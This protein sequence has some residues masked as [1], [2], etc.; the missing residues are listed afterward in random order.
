MQLN[1]R[2]FLALSLIFYNLARLAN[3]TAST[4][5]TEHDSK[6]SVSFISWN[7]E[8]S[9]VEDESINEQNIEEFLN[10]KVSLQNPIVIYQ[11][12]NFHLLQQLLQPSS[13]SYPFLTNFFES[14]NLQEMQTPSSFEPSMISDDISEKNLTRFNIDTLPSTAGDLLFNNEEIESSSIVWFQFNDDSYDLNTLDEF[15]EST[16]IFLNENTSNDCKFNVFLNS[17][18]YADNDEDLKINELAQL[19]HKRVSQDIEAL[20][21]EELKKKKN[22][23]KEDGKDDDDKLSKIWT[24]GLIMCLIVSLLLLIILIMAISWVSDIGIS[25]GALETTTNPLKK[26]N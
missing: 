9:S 1:Q 19:Y 10:D 13:S 26:N 17:L 23:S 15:L 7:S 12:T 25:Y 16:I 24:E 2:I 3:A 5:T 21:H 14:G 8:S 18:D 20:K 22:N 11:F 6:N 4:F